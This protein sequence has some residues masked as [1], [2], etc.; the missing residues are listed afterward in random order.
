MGQT[1][2][3]L[4]CQLH[5]PAARM[6]RVPGQGSRV[7]S[8]ISNHEKP[9]A[10]ARACPPAGRAEAATLGSR[11][12]G[13]RP[14]LRL[15]ATDAGP[16]QA[17]PGRIEDQ[18]RRSRRRHGQAIGAGPRRMGPARPAG[19]PPGHPAPSPCDFFLRSCS[20]AREADGGG[21]QRER[22]AR[23]VH[24]RVAR[25]RWSGVKVVPGR[26]MRG[27]RRTERADG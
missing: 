11:A 6:Q 21:A 17:M 8:S 2:S 22:A 1:A 12:H 20:S 19:W 27:S 5:G 14:S 24:A 26:R 25:E 3:T 16:Q 10:G 15:G 13:R 4:F 9:Q 23:R 7:G 18:R